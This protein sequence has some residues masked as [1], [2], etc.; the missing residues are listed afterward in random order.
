MQQRQLLRAYTGDYRNTTKNEDCASME[1]I[2]SLDKIQ[3]YLRL[4]SQFVHYRQNISLTFCH[5][6]CTACILV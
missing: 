6:W 2:I 3:L 1:I 5:P 4:V